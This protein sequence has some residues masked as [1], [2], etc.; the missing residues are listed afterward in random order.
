M[1]C[2]VKWE[3]H[4]DTLSGIVVVAAA[5]PGSKWKLIE[6]REQF[7]EQHAKHLKSNRVTHCIALMGKREPKE[8]TV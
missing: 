8:F 5:L 6:M 7:I 1:S 2:Y 3:E 4:H